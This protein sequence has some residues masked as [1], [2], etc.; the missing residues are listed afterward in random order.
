MGIIGSYAGEYGVAV[1]L[2]QHHNSE[3]STVLDQLVRLAER[4][5]LAA[6][7]FVETLSVRFQFV[8]GAR[9][10]NLNAVKIDLRLG[11]QALDRF[12]F[13]QQHGVTNPFT[14]HDMGGAEDT[15]RVRFREDYPFRVALGFGCYRPHQVASLTDPVGQFLLV[16]FDIDR[17]LRHPCIHRRLSHSRRFPDENARIERFR[18]KVLTAELEMIDTVRLGHLLRHFLLGQ[19]GQRL[20]SGN[21]HLFINGGSVHVQRTPENERE[22]QD[23]VDLVGVVAATGGHDGVRP[24]VHRVRIGDFRI[25]VGHGE[26]DGVFGH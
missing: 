2:L 3:V 1:A 23:I 9:V 22:P 24:C 16:F 6:A 20:D 11:G 17:L 26:D 10:H 18:D 25:G 15:G 12:G 7:F 5:T 4:K 21:F 14:Q 13:T 19:R 8:R